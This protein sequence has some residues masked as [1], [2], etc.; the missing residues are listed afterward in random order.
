VRWQEPDVKERLYR[1]ARE[2]REEQL[3]K[4]NAPF[5]AIFAVKIFSC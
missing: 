1:E 5:F 4:N 2:V 3:Q